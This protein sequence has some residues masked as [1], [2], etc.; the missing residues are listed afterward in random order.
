MRRSDDKNTVPVKSGDEICGAGGTELSASARERGKAVR[1]RRANLM[2]DIE[3]QVVPRL[4]LA[5][6][7]AAR[8]AGGTPGAANVP[9]GQDVIDFAQ[10]VMSRDVGTLLQSVYALQH[11][12]VSLESLYLDLLAPAARHLG[13]LWN[14]DLCDF[15]DVTLGL[16]RLQQVA[17]ELSPAFCQ[18]AERRDTQR[19][20]LLAPTPGEQ[21]TFG[22]SIVADFFRRAGWDVWAEQSGPGQDLVAIVRKEWFAVVGFSVGC[23]GK[24]E[25]LAS[26]IHAIRRASRNRNVG[27][28]VGGSIFVEHPELVALIGADATAVDGHQACSQAESLI[29]VMGARGAELRQDDG[30]G[31]T[32]RLVQGRSNLP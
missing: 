6:R 29:D 9:S 25:G 28:L 32:E 19:R 18:D 17:R 3:N 24:L 20:I 2:R 23:A 13:E 12:G 7:S 10:L 15:T 8:T 4:V 1:R 11:R 26:M 27:V 14:A 31:K 30:C 21:H 5:H 22:L 16:W